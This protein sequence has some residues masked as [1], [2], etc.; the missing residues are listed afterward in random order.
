MLK[1]LFYQIYTNGN[2]I[3]KPNKFDV[4]TQANLLYKKKQNYIQ[5]DKQA[6][7]KKPL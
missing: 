3:F 4:K 6:K 7:A 1:L 2:F 5:S